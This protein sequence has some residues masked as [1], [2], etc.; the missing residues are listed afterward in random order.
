MILTLDITVQLHVSEAQAAKI[1]THCEYHSSTISECEIFASIKSRAYFSISI[2]RAFS[3][4]FKD[5]CFF[6]S[7]ALALALALTLALSDSNVARCSSLPGDAAYQ[8]E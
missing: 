1:G 5:L 3:I 2:M 6:H 4:F 7:L 8:M